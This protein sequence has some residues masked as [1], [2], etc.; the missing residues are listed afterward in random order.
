M[1][2]SSG[3]SQIWRFH[4]VVVQWTLKKCTKKRDAPAELLSRSLKII[5]PIVFWSC[6]RRRGCLRYSENGHRKC[7]FSNTLS[8]GPFLESPANVS[9]GPEMKYSNQNVNR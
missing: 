5:K 6:R 8:G 7:I 4:F 3:K 2:T 1:S 9:A